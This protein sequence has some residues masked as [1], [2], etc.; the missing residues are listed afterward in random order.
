M[1]FINC[2]YINYVFS[3]CELVSVSDTRG[4]Y[5]KYLQISLILPQYKF[6]P[7]SQYFEYRPLNVYDF[8][9]NEWLNKGSSDFKYEQLLVSTQKE[10]VVSNNARE[11]PPT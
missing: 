2:Y 9:L 1:S 3:L 11:A 7:H 4:L 8:D 6:I 5:V 10:M